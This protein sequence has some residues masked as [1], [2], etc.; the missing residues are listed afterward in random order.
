[1]TETHEWPAWPTPDAAADA[2]CVPF[3]VSAPFRVRADLAKLDADGPGSAPLAVLDRRYPEYARAKLAAWRTLDQPSV[4]H[5]PGS[6]DSGDPVARTFGITAALA[7]RLQGDWGAG[8]V[9]TGA[10]WIRWNTSGLTVQLTGGS[11]RIAAHRPDA[12]GLARWLS[13]LAPVDALI[14]SASLSIQEDLALMHAPDGV[15]VADWL[16]VALPSGWDPEQKR[17]MGLG[18]IH[19]PVADGEAL[20]AASPNLARAMLEKGPF[21]RWVWTLAD[22]GRL[23]R[24]PR[25]IAA[26]DA[27][28]RTPRTVD[29][30]WFR[31]ER[32]TT[33]A[34]P[35]WNAALFL[36]R[37][38]VAPLAV[39]AADA[40]RRSLLVDALRSM[41]DAVVAYKNLERSRSIALAAWG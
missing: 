32:Q 8:H 16:S 11:V 2:E 28:A 18:A 26:T 14:T 31:C 41:S 22:D 33:F 19:A 12:D 35:D 23:S 15:P 17:G 4:I 5:R 39:V 10:D 36:I 9:R 40:G 6:A 7:R 37:V 13:S 3:P 27:D 1:M 38:Y 24:H 29:D 20:R 34:L 25:T 30:L 21:L